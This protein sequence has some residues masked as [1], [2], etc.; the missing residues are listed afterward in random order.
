MII[1][2][3]DLIGKEDR[4]ELKDVIVKEYKD[5]RYFQLIPVGIE[6]KICVGKDTYAGKC[7]EWGISTHPDTTSFDVEITRINNKSK[8]HP[9]FY[10]RLMARG[11]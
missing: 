8:F 4:V 9:Y 2:I 5:R 7:I 6:D 1:T 10:V 3:T 11:A